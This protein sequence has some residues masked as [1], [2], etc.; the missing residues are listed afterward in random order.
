MKT[1]KE[2]QRGIG[3]GNE[4]VGQKQ[5]KAKAEQDGEKLWRGTGFVF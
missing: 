5:R 1:T 2:S 3:Q 4:R